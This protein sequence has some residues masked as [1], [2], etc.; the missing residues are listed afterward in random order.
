MSA[1]SS[2]TRATLSSGEPELLPFSVWRGTF[3]LVGNALDHDPAMRDLLPAHANVR[4][5]DAAHGAGVYEAVV[6]TLSGA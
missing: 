2:E 5:A 4:V 3:W 6:T 1:T